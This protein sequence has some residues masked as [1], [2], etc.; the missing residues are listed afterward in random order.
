MSFASLQARRGIGD[1][2]RGVNEMSIPGS[3]VTENSLCP[4]AS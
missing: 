2:R 4:A 1:Q 3:V